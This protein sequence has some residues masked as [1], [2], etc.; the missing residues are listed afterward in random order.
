M[1][2][3]WAL[4]TMGWIKS[5]WS[6]IAGFVARYPWQALCAGLLLACAWLWYGKGVVERHEAAEKAAYAATIAQQNAAIAQWQAAGKAMQAKG[7]PA[8]ATVQ[9]ANRPMIE[10]ARYIEHVSPAPV[11]QADCRTPQ[12]VMDVKEQL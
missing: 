4:R 2:A 10:A 12:G 1:L 3:L 9:Q 5:M 7:A 11:V 6:A 8:L